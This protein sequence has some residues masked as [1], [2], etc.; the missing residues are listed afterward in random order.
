VE[1][2]KEILVMII[3]RIFLVLEKIPTHKGI[4]KGI[5]MGTP[6]QVITIKM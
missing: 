1:T 2:L 5:L 3:D 6:M 4:P